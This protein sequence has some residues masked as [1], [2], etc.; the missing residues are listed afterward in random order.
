MKQN[1]ASIE[2]NYDKK[3][4]NSGEVRPEYYFN[5]T[6]ITDAKNKITYENMMPMVMRFIR[7][8]I[9]LSL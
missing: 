6:D 1:K 4:F 5:C 9:I 8:S 7:I 2:L 3:G